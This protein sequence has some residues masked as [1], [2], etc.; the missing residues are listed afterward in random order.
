MSDRVQSGEITKWCKYYLGMNDYPAV[1]KLAGF[2]LPTTEFPVWFAALILYEGDANLSANT[3]MTLFTVPARTEVFIRA[4]SVWK[5]GTDDGDYDGLYLQSPTTAEVDKRPNSLG[6]HYID[7]ANWGDPSRLSNVNLHI[8]IAAD[9]LSYLNDNCSIYCP[10][11]SRMKLTYDFN[12]TCDQ[13]YAAFS[14][15]I[16]RW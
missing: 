6:L 16:R 12:T 4:Y 8:S 13:T 5:S 3:T 1:T 11:L 9:Q 7:G 10:P 15:F 14:C 2:V